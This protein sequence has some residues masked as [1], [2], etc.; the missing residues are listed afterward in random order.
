[1]SRPKSAIASLLGL[2]KNIAVLALLGWGGWYAYSQMAPG[3]TTE[4]NSTAGTAFDCRRAYRQRDA[5]H[6]C[7]ESDSCT[8]TSDDLA[9]L[10]HLEAEIE[11]HC[12]LAFNPMAP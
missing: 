6:A 5:D 12:S 9:A 10:K 7:I 2:V 11:E 4:V 3:S 1:M 8:M